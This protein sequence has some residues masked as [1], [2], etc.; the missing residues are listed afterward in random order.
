MGLR[1]NRESFR[2][3]HHRC[4][5]GFRGLTEVGRPVMTVGS[6]SMF[7]LTV[8]SHLSQIPTADESG[9]LLLLLL[10]LGE[11][12][13]LTSTMYNSF[14]LRPKTKPSLLQEKK[15]LTLNRWNANPPQRHPVLYFVLPIV[16][17]FN[18]NIH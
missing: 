4:E 12:P 10:P 15:T 17:T 18:L 6:A 1:E 5:K 8:S 13:G 7:T 14:T 3:T 9:C 16:S 2:Q 11:P